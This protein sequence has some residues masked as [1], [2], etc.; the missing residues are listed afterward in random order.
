MYST[1]SSFAAPSLINRIES[2]T[3]V[4]GHQQGSAV[5][6][7]SNVAYLGGAAIC[8]PMDSSSIFVI[9][10]CFAPGLA[11]M[12]KRTPPDFP[13]LIDFGIV[14]TTVFCNHCRIRNSLKVWSAKQI[15]VET[16][17]QN[18][19]TR[20]RQQAQI[21]LFSD[22]IEGR[23]EVTNIYYTPQFGSHCWLNTTGR[24]VDGRRTKSN[25]GRTGN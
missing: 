1:N 13:A 7:F 18:G 20:C 11:R 4:G 22:V 2:F 14:D 8:T 16:I 19:H 15:L 25:P 12:C 17:T 9:P 21:K 3:S 10:F 5:G 23:M 6:G 24:N